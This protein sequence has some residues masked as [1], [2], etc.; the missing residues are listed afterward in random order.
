MSRIRLMQ[1]VCPATGD[2]YAVWQLPHKDLSTG[3]G[4]RRCI[5]DER[6]NYIDG[7][8]LHIRAMQQ[9]HRYT[10][11]GVFASSFLFLPVGAFVSGYRH[12]ASLAAYCPPIHQHPSGRRALLRSRRSGEAA[13]LIPSRADTSFAAA[14]RRLQPI[15][16]SYL[17]YG[18]CVVL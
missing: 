15:C 5:K 9:E 1:I 3:D 2:K 14:L 17:L 11:L 16:S 12:S 8:L 4:R 6:R 18:G 7:S 13:R 10:V